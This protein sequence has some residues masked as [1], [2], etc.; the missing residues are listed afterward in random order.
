MLKPLRV[1]QYVNQFFGQLGGEEK[2]FV[3][4]HVK[5]GPV[6]L[7]LATQKELGDGGQVVATVIC[8]DNYVGEH[9]EE[10]IDTMI[11]LIRPYEPD[12]VIAGP[13]FNAG[14][15]GMAAGA[16]CQAVQERLGIPA[17]TGM[18]NENPGVGLYREKV[19]IIETG[20][21]S[22]NLPE[23]IHRMAKLGIKLVNK[24]RVG[25][26]REEGYFSH[27]FLV[28]ELSDKKAPER[29]VDMLLAQFRGEPIEPELKLATFD[30][31]KPAPAVKKLNEANIA[32]V[33]DGGLVPQGN[34]D[35]LEWMAATKYVT[36]D[37]SERDHLKGG[38]FYANH[39]GYDTS[40]VNDDPMRLVPLD[41]LRELEARGVVRKLNPTLY[42]TTGVATTIEYSQ[43]IGSAL[44][45]R[46][47]ADGV[48][49]VILTST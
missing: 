44:A 39:T 27:G 41:V 31:V 5:E 19:Y 43:K 18:Y 30:Q 49:A 12:L 42:S 9:L 10:A 33:T 4:P 36:I 45:E 23:I 20:S 26:P 8:G 35:K 16:L 32:L 47:K 21:T 46:L 24:E 17:V 29:A 28:N 25:K 15:Y 22:K 40:E 7:G 3:E 13:A 34:P 38:E 1:V 11:E 48:D 2:A 6:G 14:R 37:I